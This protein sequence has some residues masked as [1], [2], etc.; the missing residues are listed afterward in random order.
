VYSFEAGPGRIEVAAGECAIDRLGERDSRNREAVIALVDLE[1]DVEYA[2]RVHGD[3]RMAYVIAGCDQPADTGACLIG[4]LATFEDLDLRFRAPASGSAYLVLDDSYVIGALERS[5][6]V[7]VYRPECQDATDCTAGRPACAHSRCVECDWP[8]YCTDPARP[9]CSDAGACVAGPTCTD[10]DPSPPENGDDSP[11]GA[12]VVVPPEPG[13]QVVIA[14]RLCSL[15]D[16]WDYL[17]VDN[18]VPIDIG[19]ASSGEV[20]PWWAFYGDVLQTGSGIQELPPGRHL[21]PVGAINPTNSAETR[22]YTLTFTGHECG[23]ARDCPASAPRCNGGTCGAGPAACTGDDDAAES[24]GDDGPSGAPDITPARGATRTITSA[25]C[26]TPASELDFFAVT[27]AAGDRLTVDLTWPDPDDD[28]DLVVYRG[29]DRLGASEAFT[30]FEQV[31][32][33]YLPAGTYWLRIWKDGDPV[34]ASTPY[35]LT[36]ARGQDPACDAAAC[37]LTD[38]GGDTLRPLC[39]AGACEPVIA[40]SDQALGEVCDDQDDCASRICAAH[41]RGIEATP[42]CTVE[43]FTDADCARLGAAARCTRTEE[44]TPRWL[45][46]IAP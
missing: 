38:D 45:C 11:A 44:E 20:F 21:L 25:I 16:E 4:N 12:R 6:T 32:L 14:Q 15:D 17:V 8:H 29:R 33:R 2:V 7:E 42:V 24:G 39:A 22:A 26:N 31:D 40:S 23:S 43:C 30:G 36:V 27:V 3:V 35:T 18:D 28:L 10:D 1:P 46:A 37:A 41:V 9:I 19:F 13:Q 5:A 34:A